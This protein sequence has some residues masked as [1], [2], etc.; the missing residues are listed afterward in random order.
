MWRADL[1]KFWILSRLSS[2]ERAKARLW[3]NQFIDFGYEVPDH[4]MALL[5]GLVFCIV[6]PPIAVI[7]AAYFLVNS[8][9]ARYQVCYVY[10]PRF[11]T[12][13]QARARHAPRTLYYVKPELYHQAL[14]FCIVAPPTAVVAAPFSWIHSVVACFDSALPGPL[15][16]HAMLIRLAARR[17]CQASCFFCTILMPPCTPCTSASW[18]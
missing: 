7:A 17:A 5:L 4:M 13:G 11:E 12:G 3:E 18:P 9:I 8:I 16:I 1:I 2:T 6:A 10:S 15:C 14:V